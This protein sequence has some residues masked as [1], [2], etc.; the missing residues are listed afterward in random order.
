M[1]DQTGFEDT[2]CPYVGRLKMVVRNIQAE[3]KE[4]ENF[5]E[6]VMAFEKIALRFIQK[7]FTSVPLTPLVIPLPEQK[8]EVVAPV[9]EEIPPPSPLE[10][11]VFE[12]IPPSHVLIPVRNIYKI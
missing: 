1:T 9:S 6:K 12:E 5:H 10:P 8:E 7:D 3:L 11:G 2:E 4:H